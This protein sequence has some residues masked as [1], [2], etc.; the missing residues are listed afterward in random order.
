MSE[1][2][3]KH[4]CGVCSK[5]MGLMTFKCSCCEKEYCVTHRLPEEHQCS[6]NF[7]GIALESLKTKIMSQSTH[8]THN[9]IKL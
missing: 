2:Q 1:N 8:E 5:K 3:T 7:R 6:G 9:Y 4:R